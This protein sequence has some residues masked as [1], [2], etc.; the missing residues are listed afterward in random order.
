MSFYTVTNHL[1]PTRTVLLKML[2]HFLG[3]LPV[4]WGRGVGGGL[5]REVTVL[6]IFP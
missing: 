1:G 2:T 5:N 3:Q 4:S 6:L